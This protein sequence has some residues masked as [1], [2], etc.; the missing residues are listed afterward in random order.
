[1]TIPRARLAELEAAEAE[2]QKYRDQAH[3]DVNDLDFG[4]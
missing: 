1:V 3:R 4:A 2:V